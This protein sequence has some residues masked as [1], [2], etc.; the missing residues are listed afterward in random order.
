MISY[1]RTLKNC[2]LD[3]AKSFYRI[4][5]GMKEERKKVTQ[6]REWKPDSHSPFST[7]DLVDN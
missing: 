3:D 5:L 1:E 2:Q 6:M 7:H 4:G